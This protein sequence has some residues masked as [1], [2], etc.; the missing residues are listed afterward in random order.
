MKNIKIF[1]TCL[2]LDA[3]PAPDILLNFFLWWLDAIDG[4]HGGLG[5]R[6][7]G[8]PAVTVA[9]PVESKEHCLVDS[10]DGWR[11]DRSRLL[12]EFNDTLNVLKI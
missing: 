2:P 6:F 11:G 10:I 9:A 4:L 3:L 12:N 1:E 8:I 7:T 5:G